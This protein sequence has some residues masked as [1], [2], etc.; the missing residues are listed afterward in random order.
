MSNL[1]A[2]RLTQLGSLAY[3]CKSQFQI[4]TLRVV[5][6]INKTWSLW[7]YVSFFANVKSQEDVARTTLRYLYYSIQYTVHVYRIHWKRRSHFPLRDT[8]LN[9]HSLLVRRHSCWISAH[10][11]QA[12]V[13]KT[14]QGPRIAGLDQ[15]FFAHG[16]RNHLDLLGQALAGAEPQSQVF[17]NQHTP[18][19]HSIRTLRINVKIYL[20]HVHNRQA[21]V[22]IAVTPPPNMLV[23]V[24]HCCLDFKSQFLQCSTRSH[25]AFFVE[26]KMVRMVLVQE[27]Q[28]PQWFTFLPSCTQVWQ[29]MADLR[30]V[31]CLFGTL[32]MRQ[33]GDEVWHQRCK[34]DEVRA[35]VVPCPQRPMGSCRSPS[36]W[37]VWDLHLQGMFDQFDPLLCY[38]STFQELVIPIQ[39]AASWTKAE[40]CFT[41]GTCWVEYNLPT[42]AQVF[43]LALVEIES[44]CRLADT[45]F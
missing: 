44:P 25:E 8:V 17:S 27:H 4:T 9:A 31:P 38:L 35:T 29:C 24:L 5:Q 21:H 41:S 30:S 18:P 15:L 7:R 12:F 28:T 16:S 14:H 13:V 26:N 43:V 3:C 45:W 22:F 20:T 32:F 2:E 23:L 1:E 39:N 11:L 10:C 19:L 34:G 42:G 37:P 6:T 40:I 36:V 33:V